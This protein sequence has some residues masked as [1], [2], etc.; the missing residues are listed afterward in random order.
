[1]DKDQLEPHSKLYDERWFDSA[2]TYVREAD[3]MAERRA[4]VVRERRARRKG[5]G[6]GKKDGK[7]E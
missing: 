2:V 5:D 1:M 7:E 3:Q 4:K 6:K